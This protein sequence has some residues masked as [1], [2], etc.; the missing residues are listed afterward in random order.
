VDKHFNSFI[1]G[2]STHVAIYDPCVYYNKLLGG[3]YIYLLLYA[4]DMLIAF[5]S[6]HAIDKLKKDLSSEFE[7]KDLGEVKKMLGNEIE[8]DRKSGKVSLTQKGY[9]QKVPQRLNINGD[10]KS[11]STPL[12]PQFKLKAT[13]SSTT[14][15]KRKYMTRVP[16]AS[17]VGSLM[18]AMVCRR[19]DLS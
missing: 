16:Y 6:R 15:E 1:K 5:K 17:A 2:K 3:E 7:M 10:T 14:V 9:L 13:I 4:D 12:A 19:S 11:V 8:R 18:Y